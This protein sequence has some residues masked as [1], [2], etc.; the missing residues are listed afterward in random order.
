M[1]E[2]TNNRFSHPLRGVAAAAAV[3]G[4]LTTGVLVEARAADRDTGTVH[5]ETPSRR[6]PQGGDQAPGER[7]E[8]QA[9]DR[10][11]DLADQRTADRA[12]GQLAFPQR[13]C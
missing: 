7:N 1:S 13:A 3:L 5:V 12:C 6:G 2:L 9:R 4:L 11:T 8:R 10:L